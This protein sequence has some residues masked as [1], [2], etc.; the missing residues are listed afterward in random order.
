VILLVGLLLAGTPDIDCS[1]VRWFVSTY[2]KPEAL[3]IARKW[4]SD[5]QI[6][7]AEAKCLKR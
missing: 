6:R 2:G 4:Y 3:R 7:T 5:D 1:K